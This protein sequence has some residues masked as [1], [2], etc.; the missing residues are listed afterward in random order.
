MSEVKTIDHYKDW[1]RKNKKKNMYLREKISLKMIKRINPEKI[2]DV[3][4]GNGFFM[5]KI[6]ISLPKTEILGVEYSKHNINISRKKGF[7]VKKADL[8]SKIPYQDKGFDMVYAGEII[9]HL[10]NP[11]LFLR[12]V[13][14]VLKDKG[15]FIL[16]TPN[17]CAWF[18]RILVPL[19]IQPVF[20]ETSTESKLIGAGPLLKFKKES[21][22]VG[23]IR[24]FNLDAITDILK[25][26]K[27]KI[28]QTK[29]AVFDSFFPKPFLFI[30][31]LFSLIP[32]LAA[33]LVILSRK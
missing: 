12:E 5:E 17:L 25:K 20:V 11:D 13:Y 27:F 24:V 3:G 4:C 21:L 16:S 6:K 28:L 15:Y 30:D 1:N 23:H 18:N 7:K 14:R 26:E 22:P 9:E 32:N 8:N 10:Y 29:G 33:D 2:L 19:G 31:R